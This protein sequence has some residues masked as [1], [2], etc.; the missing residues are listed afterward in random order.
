MSSGFDDMFS[1]GAE[2]RL[3]RSAPLAA[4]MRPATLDEVVGQRHLLGPGKPLRALIQA[5]LLSSTRPDLIPAVVP[6]LTL[7]AENPASSDL[8]K[9]R[10]AARPAW[11][12]QF[13]YEMRQTITD[14]RTPLNL[15]M[16]MKAAGDP[17]S[18]EELRQYLGFLLSRNFHEI[19]YY[20]W[21][22]FLPMEQLAVTGHLFNGNFDFPISGLP[23]DWT[24]SQGVGASVDIV[25]PP[26]DGGNRALK[27]ELIS[28]RV[29]L[30]E[31]SQR[32]MLP[33]GKYVLKAKFRGEVAGRRGMRWRLA[34]SVDTSK[35]LTE[36]GMFIGVQRSWRDIEAAFSVPDNE[37][38]AQIIRLVHDARYSAEQFV[39]GTIWF[40]DL[41]I[42]RQ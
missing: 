16:G 9:K 11:R 5:D 18:A 2:E 22:Q 7:L 23:F 27:V 3:R 15:M 40:D 14:A 37:C 41:V 10:L 28:G 8:L 12:T 20:A 34:C 29:Q 42:T 32:L 31:I 38:R 33:P 1:A 17:P 24:I 21:L 4:R 19:A 39:T 6:L 36:T 26:G 13:F 30:G 35:V 25:V